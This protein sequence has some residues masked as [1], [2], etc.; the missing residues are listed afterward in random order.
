VFVPTL[1]VTQTVLVLAWSMRR[2]SHVHRCH[3]SSDSPSP[4]TGDAKA[5]C[6]RTVFRILC[7]TF[8]QIYIPQYTIKDE[9]E[10]RRTLS[11]RQWFSPH[12]VLSLG[13]IPSRMKLQT[14]ERSRP[15]NGMT[16]GRAT[17]ATHQACL[18]L[19]SHSF[20]KHRFFKYLC[21]LRIAFRCLN[22]VQIAPKAPFFHERA[23]EAGV[24][25]NGA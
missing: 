17:M 21:G 15:D 20:Q 19:H 23:S 14:A 12:G 18:P 24:I 11:L 25:P 3:L 8:A 4:R 22:I 16:S 9:A 7:Y 10:D 2:K 13:S 1:L 6:V 5:R